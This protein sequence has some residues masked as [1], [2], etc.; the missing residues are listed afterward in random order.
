MHLS[1]CHRNFIV[2]FLVQPTR[3]RLWKVWCY[4]ILRQH[5]L[6]QWYGFLKPIS[7]LLTR[8]RREC[9]ENNYSTNC[10]III[11]LLIRNLFPP[12]MTPH[13]KCSYSIREE[14]ILSD[15]YIIRISVLSEMCNN[16]IMNFI[17]LR[18]IN[19]MFPLKL[20]ILNFHCHILI[21]FII[22]LNG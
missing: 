7:V 3:T 14:K 18:Y 21:H 2:R 4:R 1:M 22:S 9:S 8:V 5:K 17:Y 10:H 11:W 6:E 15:K 13:N 16:M 12:I 19:D 20:F